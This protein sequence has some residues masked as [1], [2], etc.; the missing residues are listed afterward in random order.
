MTTVRKY[1]SK[2]RQSTTECFSQVE[3]NLI[4]SNLELLVI[5]T[6]YTEAMVFDTLV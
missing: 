2:R 5:F 6:N 1:Q 4:K 3:N